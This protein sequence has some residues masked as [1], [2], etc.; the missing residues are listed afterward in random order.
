MER[1]EALKRILAADGG[2]RLEAEVQSMG[3]EALQ[4]ASKAANLPV[5]GSGKAFLVTALRSALLA[6]LLSAEDKQEEAGNVS[7]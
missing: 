4:Q 5:G 1:L 3:R 6:H 2:E 7:G